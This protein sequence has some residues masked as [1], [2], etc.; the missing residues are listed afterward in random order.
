MSSAATLQ[1]R[2]ADAILEVLE[3]SLVGNNWPRLVAREALRHLAAELTAHEQLAG[4]PL[5][6]T[7]AIAFLCG[8]SNSQPSEK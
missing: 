7:D 2:L 1:D 3:D 5:A 8:Q 4:R 6:Y